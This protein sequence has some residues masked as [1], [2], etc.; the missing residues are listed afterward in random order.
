MKVSE[1]WLRE[2]VD[3]DIDSVDELNQYQMGQDGEPYHIASK[4]KAD[5][6][7]AGTAHGDRI[8]ANGLAW[9][10]CLMF[11]DQHQGHVRRNKA[12]VHS[13]TEDNVPRQSFAARRAEYLKMRR[14]NKQKS[15]W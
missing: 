6:S 4:D 12:N 14:K 11:G 3:P 2:W 8:I 13:A 1:S 15:N 10:A 5:P 7:G 9:H